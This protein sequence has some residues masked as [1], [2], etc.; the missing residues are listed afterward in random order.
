M[1]KLLGI[2]V[3]G[4]LLNR[5]AY[6]RIPT[7]SEDVGGSFDLFSLVIVLVL[8][9]IGYAYVTHKE[10]KEIKKWDD[11]RKERIKKD[12]ALEKKKKKRK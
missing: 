2:V 12:A 5:N 9:G 8:I 4:L 6:A 3:L 1:K 11:V 7:F 10:N